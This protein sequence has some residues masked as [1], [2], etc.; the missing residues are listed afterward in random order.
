LI[1]EPG[2]EASG[3]GLLQFFVGGGSAIGLL[4]GGFLEEQ[5]GPKEMYRVSSAI[6]LIGSLIFAGPLLNNNRRK[7]GWK[8]EIRH[9]PIP[10]DDIQGNV[11]LTTS[12][13]TA[14]LGS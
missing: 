7:Q 11:E 10:Q 3:Q 12:P 9:Q 8:E 1:P 14:A 5:Y 6:V 2:M 4:L 13:D